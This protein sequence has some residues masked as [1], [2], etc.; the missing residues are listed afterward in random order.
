MADNEK[1]IMSKP[2]KISQPKLLIINKKLTTNNYAIA[3]GFNTFINTTARKIGE[4]IIPTTYQYQTALIEP[5]QNT[6]TLFPTTE[7]E[8]NNQLGN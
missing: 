6:M 2:N 1:L 7:D 5:N 3:T 8:I 4:K